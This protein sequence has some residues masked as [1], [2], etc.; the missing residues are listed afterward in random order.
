LYLVE[1]SARGFWSTQPGE[2]L[3]SFFATLDLLGVTAEKKNGRM[4]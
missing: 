1:Y 2:Q 4:T 3:V